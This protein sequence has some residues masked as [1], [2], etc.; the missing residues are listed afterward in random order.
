MCA[1]DGCGKGPL[2]CLLEQK[3]SLWTVSCMSSTNNRQPGA[4][5]VQSS[6][7]R[8][9]SHTV[10][11]CVCVCTRMCTRVCVCVIKATTLPSSG[12]TICCVFCGVPGGIMHTEYNVNVPRDSV[13]H[14]GPGQH[15][16]HRVPSHRTPV[17]S[18]S[19]PARPAPAL[20]QHCYPQAPSHD[21]SL[22]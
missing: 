12:S 5:V 19:I 2:R 3:L 4:C 22:I 11:A 21:S 16:R 15:G 9:Q 7:G 1:C 18:P 10:L 8:Q 6:S 14:R 13:Q 20:R 17:P